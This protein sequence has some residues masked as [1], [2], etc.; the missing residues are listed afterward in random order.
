M[1]VYLPHLNVAVEIEDDPLSLPVDRDAY[2][3]VIV[4]KTTCGELSNARAFERLA[5]RIA[6][7][8]GVSYQPATP[9]HR[10][11]RERLLRD[12]DCML[13]ISGYKRAMHIA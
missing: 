9:E 5:Q 13:D 2:P 1:A 4:I 7:A 8:A 3:D 12:L 6:R 10:A 11:A